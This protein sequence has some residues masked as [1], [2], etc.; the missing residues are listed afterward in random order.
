MSTLSQE[1]A[2]V[3]LSR[4]MH[5]CKHLTILTI[6]YS[7]SGSDSHRVGDRFV[8]FFSRHLGKALNFFLFPSTPLDNFPCTFLASLH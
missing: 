4:G 6:S 8:A 1:G 5:L 7:A 3:S 2:L